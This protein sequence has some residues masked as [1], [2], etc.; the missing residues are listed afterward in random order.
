MNP[1]KVVTAQAVGGAAGNMITAH[2]VVAAS[3]TVGLLAV[4]ATK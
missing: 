4:L 1:A 2:N 3:T